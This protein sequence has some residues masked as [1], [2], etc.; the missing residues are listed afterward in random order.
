[1]ENKIQSF[2]LSASID[3]WSLPVGKS[4]SSSFKLL[5]A[6]RGFLLNSDYWLILTFVSAGSFLLFWVMSKNI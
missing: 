6:Q 1:M 3:P 5:K 4:Q 2:R